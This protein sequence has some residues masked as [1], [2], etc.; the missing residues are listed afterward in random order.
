MLGRQREDEGG[1]VGSP[2]VDFLQG[3]ETLGKVMLTPPHLPSQLC[4]T[5][6]KP[7]VFARSQVAH[8]G[9]GFTISPRRLRM[10]ESPTLAAGIGS[11]RITDVSPHTKISLFLNNNSYKCCF[12]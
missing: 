9:P 8:T 4:R 5:S 6:V 10:P 11:S 7:V 1:D 3:C 2:R 12:S